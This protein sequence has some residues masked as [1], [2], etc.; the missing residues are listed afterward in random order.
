MSGPARPSWF[1]RLLLSMRPLGDRRADTETDLIELF[2]TRVEEHGL[3]HARR[4]YLLDVLSL[5]IRL[6]S[7]RPTEAVV[8]APGQRGW[9]PGALQDMKY[10]LRV[11]RRQPAVVSVAIAGLA[12]S[13]ALVTIVFTIF[14][15]FT[16]RPLGVPDPDG[17]V[18]VHR[19]VG[20]TRTILDG[21]LYPDYVR[22][23]EAARLVNLEASIPARLSLS[24][25][26]AGAGAREVEVRFIAG[27]FARTFGARAILGRLIDPSDDISGKPPVAVLH[28]GFWRSQ[29]R[30]DPSVLG[31]SFYFNG[32]P[33][34]V[35]G[36]FDP[37]STG[38]F[39]ANFN[40]PS[41]QLPLSAAQAIEPN[42]SEAARRFTVYVIGQLIRPATI[43]QAE[44]EVSAVAAGLGIGNATNSPAGGVVVRP[45]GNQFTAEDLALLSIFMTIVGLVLLLA[46][47]N[48]TNLLLA[49]STS[50][51]QEIV[52]RLALG[53][54]R[55]RIVRQLTTESVLLG[56]VSGVT[57]LAAA[58]WLLP[59]VAWLI[60]IPPAVELILDVRVYAFASVISLFVGVA[61]GLAP[62]RVGTRGNLVTALKGGTV[63]SGA[64]QGGSRL[65]STFLG[66]QAAASIML[67]VLTALFSRVLIES[68]RSSRGVDSDRVIVMSA[69]APR[70]GGLVPADQFWDVALARV[71]ALP[72]VEMTALVEDPPYGS[73]FH[74]VAAMLDGR[75]Y[76]LVQNKCSPD[77]FQ[78]A[79]L[80]FQQGRTFTADEAGSNAPVAVI[81]SALAR[82]FWPAGDALGSTLAPVKSSL[83]DV[84]VI[85]IVTDSAPKIWPP[86]Y[87]R[88]ATIF[89]PLDDLEVARM[90]VR[91]AKDSPPPLQAIRDA[92]S[93]VDLRRRPRVASLTEGIQREL[94]G[95]RLFASGAAVLGGLALTLAVIGIFGVTTFVVNQR[96][97]EISIR[98]AIGASR[99]HVVWSVFT[100]GMRPI[101]I[102]LAVG[103]G[104][105][106]FGTE[107]IER[108]LAGISAHDPISVSAATA[109][110]LT[111]A[112]LGV[113]IPARK[114]A[115][116]DPAAVLK[117]Q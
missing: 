115:R 12:V 31:R 47:I 52:A 71:R 38:P 114:A 70:T 105:A 54:S 40:P 67:L 57:G 117:E 36:V 48:V 73:G 11:F 61:A 84:R 33:V 59:T 25:T 74:P 44:A 41:I 99:S 19:T 113:L 21:W 101:V 62:A 20:N 94:Q 23:R 60:D 42:A 3:R 56:I 108:A 75:R 86:N 80:R 39:E 34:P 27:T 51:Q 9:L 18:K 1:A 96:R 65:R 58:M 17:V 68:Y 46:V 90:I 66:I 91:V 111:A 26:A 112:S 116:V 104:L 109:V 81:T 110:L 6:P 83:K 88:A 55:G 14:N 7:S 64:A 87:A 8:R 2:M 49:G 103:L 24:E 85:G 15:A 16:F 76:P 107:T 77:Y 89:R 97:R 32:V 63:Q 30:S 82:D 69:F 37:A 43:A 95:P 93:A 22:L 53:A 45:G 92:V 13:I 50:R 28:Y 72:G 29:F 79:G 10:A 100:Q 106:F 35:V 5:W 98:M 102:G 78:T 4:R